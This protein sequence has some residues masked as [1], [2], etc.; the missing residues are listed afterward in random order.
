MWI[1][2]LVHASGGGAH[3]SA[4]GSRVELVAHAGPFDAGAVAMAAMGCRPA[5]AIQR[6][7]LAA[8]PA[9]APAHDR[10]ARIE[11]TIL[12]PLVAL[13]AAVARAEADLR[14]RANRSFL[15]KD[16]GAFALQLDERVLV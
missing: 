4:G 5:L 1:L 11:R 2:W 14:H 3:L 8:P 16:V 12:R 6:L 9:L 7:T 15:A 10:V 13:L